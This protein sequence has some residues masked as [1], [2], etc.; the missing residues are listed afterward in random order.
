MQ[1]SME[2]RKFISDN[3]GVVLRP[4]QDSTGNWTIGCGHLIQEGESFPDQITFDQAMD[5]LA[6]D[7]QIAENAVNGLGWE[8]N[9][10]Q[11][12]ALVD[13]T[14]NAGIGAIRQLAAH[15]QDD[16]PNQL[17]RWNKSGGRALAGLSRRRAAEVDL[18]NSYS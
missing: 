12:D 2:G 14:F 4:Y 9:Q 5:L 18:W 1:T 3:E 10:G 11:F 6:Q 8:L 13:F 7:L 15:G 16:V 17:P